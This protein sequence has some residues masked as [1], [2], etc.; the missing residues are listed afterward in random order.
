M[1][2]QIKACGP[3]SHRHLIQALLDAAWCLFHFEQTDPRAWRALAY[4]ME[5]ESW[6]EA[7]SAWV[8]W[9]K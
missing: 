5:N 4:R 3:V 9:L 6:L 8:V 7:G 1:R 2:N